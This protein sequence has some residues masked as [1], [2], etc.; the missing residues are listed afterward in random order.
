MRYKV[1]VGTLLKSTC[2]LLISS[3]VPLCLLWQATVDCHPYIA[4]ETDSSF[5]H[6]SS[7]WFVGHGLDMVSAEELMALSIGVQQ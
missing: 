5:D 4:I 6:E 1:S 3:R 2:I 7:L